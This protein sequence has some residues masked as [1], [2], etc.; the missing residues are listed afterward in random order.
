MS[1]TVHI[2]YVDVSA[3][4]NVVDDKVKGDTAAIIFKIV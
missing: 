4:E 2:K 3:T 1:M